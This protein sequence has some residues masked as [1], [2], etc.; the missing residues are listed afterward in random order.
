MDGKNFIE[1]LKRGDPAGAEI[2]MQQCKPL[3]TY[4]ILPILSDECDR[5][6]RPSE[7]IVKMLGNVLCSAVRTGNPEM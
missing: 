4:L 7:V 5:E 2:L 6:D 1:Q 3:H